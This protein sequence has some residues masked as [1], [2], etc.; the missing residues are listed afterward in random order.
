MFIELTNKKEGMKQLIN[1]D[2]VQSF[3]ELNDGC[4]IHFD[5]NSV[6]TVE[7]SYKVISDKLENVVG[8]VVGT[9]YF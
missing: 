1:L 4:Y 8:L 9:R 5:D 3:T 6:V 2:L 7:E